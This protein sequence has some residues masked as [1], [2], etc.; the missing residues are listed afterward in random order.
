[1]SSQLKTT[2][3]FTWNKIKK[4]TSILSKKVLTWHKL[5]GN[6]RFLKIFKRI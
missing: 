3:L 5:K 4:I 1:M 6:N 2:G